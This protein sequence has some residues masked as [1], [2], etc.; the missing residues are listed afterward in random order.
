LAA[1]AH[2]EALVQLLGAWEHRDAEQVPSAQALGGKLQAN[3]R[4]AWAKALASAATAG[5]VDTPVLRLE[6]AAEVP[7]A[8]EHLAQRRMLQL[9][10]LTQ[11]NAASPAESWAQDVATVLQSPYSALHAKRVQA[12][13]KV[14]LK[15]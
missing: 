11:R 15:R 2:G 12:A 9:Q 14:I 5:S 10:L 7:T 13:L 1:Q 8:A 4:A 6:I 3:A